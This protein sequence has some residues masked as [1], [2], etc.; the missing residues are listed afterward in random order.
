VWARP[1]HDHPIT[2]SERHIQIYDSNAAPEPA[3]H[4][5][6][7]PSQVSVGFSI[8]IPERS[9]LVLYPYSHRERNPFNTSAGLRRHLQPD[10]LPEVVLPRARELELD[11]HDRDVVLFPGSTMWHLRRHAAGALNLYLKFNDLGCDPLGEDPFTEQRRQATLAALS[12]AR[13]ETVDGVVMVLARRFDSASR[14]YTRDRFREVLEARVFGEEPFG[15]T[16]QQFAALHLIDGT[17]TLGAVAARLDGDDP[18]AA[19]SDLV[20]LAELGAVDLLDPSAT[21][22]G[23]QGVRPADA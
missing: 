4:K 13:A 7:F 17:S 6:R 9:R 22:A 10:E 2:L 8:S 12:T 18:A 15:L 11:D 20:R 16:E 19:R 3:A 5:D 21:G 1:Q 23:G 14:T